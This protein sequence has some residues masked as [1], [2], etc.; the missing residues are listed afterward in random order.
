MH[1]SILLLSLLPVSY[2]IP[3]EP[4]AGTQDLAPQVL[5]T[6]NELNTAVAG[7]TTAVT[8]FDGSFLGLLPQALAVVGAETKLDVTILKATHITKQSSNFTAAESSQIVQT[9]AGEIGP[10]QTSLDTLKTKY[11]AF[12]KTLLSPIVLFDLKVLK[13]H[14][15]DLISALTEKVTPDNAGLLGIGATILDQAFDSA[16]AVYKG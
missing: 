10:I 13:K 4:R 12:K 1:Y 9:L 16:I 8:N 6:I 15:H 3:V 11:P 2:S 7:L 14:T 5:E